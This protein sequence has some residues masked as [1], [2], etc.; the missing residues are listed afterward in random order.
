MGVVELVEITGI[1]LVICQGVRWREKGR[2]V[3]DGAGGEAWLHSCWDLCGWR[4]R[5]GRT[6]R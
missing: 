5:W 1:V 4:G 3:E 2:S 6:W